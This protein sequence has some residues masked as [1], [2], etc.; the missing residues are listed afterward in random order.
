MPPNSLQSQRPRLQDLIVTSIQHI[1][2]GWQVV[3]TSPALLQV[4]GVAYLHSV[5]SGIH[6]RLSIL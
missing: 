4:F 6:H 5:K 3:K 2:S 1:H